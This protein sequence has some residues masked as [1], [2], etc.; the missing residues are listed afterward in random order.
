[1]NYPLRVRIYVVAVSALGAAGAAATLVLAGPGWGERWWIA[2]AFA[3]VLLVGSLHN[4]RSTVRGREGQSTTHDES[5]IVA[6]LFLSP[7]AAI[8]SSIVLETLLAMTALRRTPLKAVFNV[9]KTTLGVSACLL[10]AGPELPLEPNGRGI[11]AA[12]AGI[13]V[14]IAVDHLAMAGVMVSIGAARARDFLRDD[15]GGLSL[16]WSANV[17][18]G[19]LAGI[20]AT[21]DPWMLPLAV[22]AMLPLHFALSGHVQAKVQSQ[23]LEE[24]IGASSDGIVAVDRPGRVRVWSAAMERISGVPAADAVG[25]PVDDLLELVGEGGARVS[26]IAG[27]GERRD[28]VLLRADGHRSLEL[29]CGHLPDEGHVLIVHDATE[30][31]RTRAALDEREEHLRQAQKLETIGHLAG[32]IAHDFNNV[33]VAIGGYSELALLELEEDHPARA[34]VAEI[35]TA[36]SRATDLTR[37]L[38]DYSRRRPVE[39]R[40]LELAAVV[41]DLAPML[42]RLVGSGI[43]IEIEH[44]PAVPE[45]EADPTQI[46]QIVMNLALNGRDAMPGGGTLT[47]RTA[48]SGANALLEV[49]DTGGG[50]DAETASQVFEPFFTTKRAGEG[51][52]LGLST[53]RLIAAAAGGSVGVASEPGRGTAFSVALPA[54]GAVK[55]PPLEQSG[56]HSG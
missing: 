3:A 31:R 2:P 42:R 10:V 45:V 44:A 18:I 38:L 9:G 46:G 12:L 28:A 11:V 48:A 53:V 29:S 16:V 21:L 6:L 54:A 49:T 55:G 30:A 47:I 51:T 5:L 36:T 20:A 19:L 8:L 39:R 17:A 23:R 37:N 40:R 43:R 4:L 25:A 1:M 32:G 26:P 22:G 13:S 34:D 41:D 27:V 35:V 52:G 50:M 15:L 33:L 24:V 7:A 14:F 56:V